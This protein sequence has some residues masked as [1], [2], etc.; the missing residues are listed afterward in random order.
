MTRGITRHLRHRGKDIISS[1]DAVA[2]SIARERFVKAAGEAVKF[3]KLDNK[4]V[5][6]VIGKNACS[7]PIPIVKSGRQWVFSTEEGRQ[8]IFNRR[9]GRNELN[10]IQVAVNYVGAQ[11]EYVSK[12]LD[13]SGVLQYAQRFRSH[14]GKR[15]ACTGKQRQGRRRVLWGRWLPVPRKRDT[16]PGN[17][18]RSG[19]RTTG[20]ISIS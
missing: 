15:M 17:R 1:G 12:D 19:S 5:L 13:G 2:D 7:F 9:I 8:E 18:A 4:T 20:I 3:S 16:L 11:R 6:P 10:T 14:K